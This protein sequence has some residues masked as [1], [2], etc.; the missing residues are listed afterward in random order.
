[1]NKEKIEEVL[2]KFSDSM[3]VIITHCCD[4]GEVTEPLPMDMIEFII[5]SWCDTVSSLDDLG[6]N[7]RTEL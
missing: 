2:S 1:M 4:D 3:G 5:S 7:V 6:I